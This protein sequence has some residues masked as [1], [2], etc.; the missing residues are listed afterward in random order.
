MC[1][2]V[3]ETYLGVQEE[4]ELGAVITQVHAEGALELAWSFGVAQIRARWPG[5]YIPR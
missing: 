3:K 2:E 4:V 5:L 1:K